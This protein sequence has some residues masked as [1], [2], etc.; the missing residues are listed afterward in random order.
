MDGDLQPRPTAEMALR[1][2]CCTRSALAPQNASVHAQELGPEMETDTQSHEP[3]GRLLGLQQK[4]SA[5][6]RTTTEG[7]PVSLRRKPGLRTIR[8]CSA[9]GLG[10]NEVARG[11]GQAP[12]HTTA[13]STMR[14]CLSLPSPPSTPCLNTWILQTAQNGSMLFPLPGIT[15]LPHL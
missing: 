3:V 1:R 8:W 12:W 4:V 13:I 5:S 11:P 10:S 7:V 9:S 15:T 14:P 6:A 2:Q